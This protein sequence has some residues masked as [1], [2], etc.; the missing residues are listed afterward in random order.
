MTFSLSNVIESVLLY[1]ERT[2]NSSDY[3][4]CETM[5]KQEETN[6]MTIMNFTCHQLPSNRYFKYLGISVCLRNRRRDLLNLTHRN[7]Y[8]HLND[9]N[10]MNLCVPIGQTHVTNL[11]CD[12]NN[13]ISLRK[14]PI[15]NYRFLDSVDHPVIL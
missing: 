5:F 9:A 3:K 1:Q 15:N 13:Y 6:R 2:S 7:Y 14:E 8:Y 10:L 12:C 4:T 11:N